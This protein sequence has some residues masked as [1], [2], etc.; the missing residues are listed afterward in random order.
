MLR[1]VF[2]L[3]ATFYKM[4]AKIFYDDLDASHNLY[5]EQ[6]NTVYLYLIG[7]MPMSI[8]NRLHERLANI[9]KRTTFM[10]VPLF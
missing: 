2:D 9:G 7:S 6:L 10:G 1:S 4:L 3:M 5:T 8:C